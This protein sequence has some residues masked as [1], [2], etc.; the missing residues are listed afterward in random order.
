MTNN[1]NWWRETTIYQIYPR[2][3]Y[4]SNGDGIGDLQGIISKLDYVKDLGFETVWLSPHYASPQRDFGYDITDY[5]GVAPEYGTLDDALQ[6]IEEAH[7]RDM[8]VLFDMILNHTSDQHPW[9]LESR[10]SRDNP[11]RDWYIWRDGKDGIKGKKPPNNWASIPGGSGWKYDELTGQ[12]FFHNFM[13]FQPD[14]NFRNPEVKAA[15]FDTLRFWLDHGVDG[16]RL[17]I[18]HAV[19]KDEQFRDNPFSWRMAPTADQS[20]GYLQK[21]VYNLNRPETFALAKEVRALI[22]EYSP[23]R[24]V[25][26]EVFGDGVVKKYLGESNDG[27]S[28]DG[29]KNDGLNAVLLF[30]LIHMDKPSADDIRKMIQSYERDYPEPLRPT[31]ALGNHDRRRY[32]SRI[33]KDVALAKLLAFLVYTLRGIPIN[34]YGDELGIPDGDFPHKGAKDAMAQP[35]WWLPRFVARRLDLYINRDGC[36]TPMQWDASSNAGF[37]ACT[38]WL[39]VQDNYSECNVASQQKDEYS[40]WSLHRKLLQLRQQMKCLRRGQLKLLDDQE[41]PGDIVAYDRGCAGDNER[42]RVLLN[43]AKRSTAVSVEGGFNRIVLSSDSGCELV[44]GQLQL[45]AY[46]AVVLGQ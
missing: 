6:L 31:F 21:T 5:C 25:V 29:G 17:D 30:D 4:D 2:S 38:P 35:Y 28:N 41:M 44:E 20:E 14:L 7:K 27:P 11:K 24:F 18:F 33:G 12:W 45:A 22:D 1:Y 37:S 13:D 46:S 16:F 36:R 26:G 3:F 8:K 39:P 42:V 19:Y 34:Y 40:L 23:D 32:F 15:M 10:S 43:M 9:F